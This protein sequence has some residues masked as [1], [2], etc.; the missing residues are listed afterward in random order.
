MRDIPKRRITL[1]T[2]RPFVFRDEN[3]Y[4]SKYVHQSLGTLP[5][6]TFNGGSV[7]MVFVEW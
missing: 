5:R 6:I 4:L 1:D 2:S 7:N 3:V